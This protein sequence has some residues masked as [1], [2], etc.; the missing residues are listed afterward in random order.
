MTLFLL[1]AQCRQKKLQAPKAEGF[2]PPIPATLSYVAG[3]ITFQLRELAEKINKELDPVLVG[4]ETKHGKV[5]GIISFR[6]KRLGPVQV[7]YVNHQIKLSAPLQMWL[8]KPFS[9]D[10]TPPKR[11]FCALHVNFQTPIGVTPKWRLDSRTQFTDYQWIVKPE[12][13]LLGGEISLTK[14]AQR[15]LE[16]HKT[17]IEAA[18]DSAIHRDLRLDQMVK[19][20][21]HD[22]QNPLL[23][24][25][26]YGLWLVPKPISVAAGQ[27]NGNATQL[28]T[29]IRI[30]FETQTELKP[31]APVHARTPLPL[32]QKREQV[33]Q[34][35]DLHLMSFIP[36]ADINRMLAITVNSQEKKLMLGA[37]TIKRAS[38]Y[39]GQRSLIVKAEVDGLLD[40]TVY[41]KGRP[42][43]DTLT[44]TLRVMNLDFDTE[45]AGLLS[46]NTNGL[47]HKALRELLANLLTIRLGDD[48]AKLPQTIDTA[49]EQGGAGKK[50]DLGI[51]T[52]RFTPQK[53][54]IRPDGIQS[55]IKVE[56]K[57]GIK[58]NQL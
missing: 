31:K 27:V 18:I 52:F 44:N 45:T 55:L 22:L 58:V 56:S 23:I 49:F 36:Y 2:D 48:L 6:V 3:T 5:K 41:L 1:L 53:I 13:R 20:I 43:F 16:S 21:W 28:S 25:K 38:V 29:P 19:P 14:L 12:V 34:T 47:G 46:K 57:V 32:L 30:A 9:K 39:G 33:S 37:L 4:K 26:E 50:T 15:I 51:Q 24:N 17:D 42:T 54:A 8:T 40:G 35:S 10:T 7:Q 11:P